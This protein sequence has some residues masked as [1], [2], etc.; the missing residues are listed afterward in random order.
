M[1]TA[2]VYRSIQQEIWLDSQHARKHLQL[3]DVPSCSRL[4]HSLT[5]LLPAGM[6]R[7]GD[8]VSSF[9]GSSILVTELVAI[10]G[11]ELAFLNERHFGSDSP[12]PLTLQDPVAS[13]AREQIGI[14][15]G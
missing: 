13:E 2:E 14:F 1:V 11:Y 7:C 3:S 5:A 9:T 12:Q 6:E 8:S 4:K 15:C 10:Y